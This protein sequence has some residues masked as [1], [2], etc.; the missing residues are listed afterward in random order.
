MILEQPTG[1]LWTCGPGLVRT[2]CS[3]MMSKV[4][5]MGV[6]KRQ[7]NTPTIME[8]T[9][10]P[11]QTFDMASPRQ[12]PKRIIKD[13]INATTHQQAGSCH[14]VKATINTL[15]PKDDHLGFGWLRAFWVGTAC[16]TTWLSN[17]SASLSIQARDNTKSSIQHP[18][19]G[20]I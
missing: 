4:D 20:K 5:W 13:G 15:E 6:P 11:W 2:E 3:R 1:L 9:G 10:R 19:H 12:R 16:Y 7:N 14:R 8:S 17:H 18:K